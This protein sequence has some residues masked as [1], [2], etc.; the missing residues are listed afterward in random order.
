[1]GG[2]GRPASNIVISNVP[3]LQE[4]RYI[5]GSTM[6]EYYPIS[7]LFHGQALNITAVSNATMFCIGF[8]G[9]RE[10]LPSLQKIAVYM[11]EAL[12]EL[13]DALGITW[14]D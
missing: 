14:E 6:E 2:I 8:T 11:G 5:E 9:C 10:T 3:G 13:E 4:T 12:V 7:L 1:M